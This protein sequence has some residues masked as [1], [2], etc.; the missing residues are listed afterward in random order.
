MAQ[1]MQQMETV[2]VSTLNRP[3]SPPNYMI[4]GISSSYHV[5]LAVR[6]VPGSY[7]HSCGSKQANSVWT[8]CP[9]SAEINPGAPESQQLPPAPPSHQIPVRSVRWHQSNDSCQ[10]YAPLCVW[11]KTAHV[12]GRGPPLTIGSPWCTSVYVCSVT[13]GLY[14]SIPPHHWP[15]WGVTLYKRKPKGCP[16]PKSD[17]LMTG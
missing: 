6:A 8:E 1:L 10:A 16:S 3:F 14:E 15:E 2:W 5:M 7:S 17:N 11:V 4:A 13:T 12:W 9:R